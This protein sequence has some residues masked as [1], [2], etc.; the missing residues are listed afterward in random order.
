L[1]IDYLKP[2]WSYARRAVNGD[3]VVGKYI[4]L[5]C[6]RML[7]WANRTDIYFDE[8]DVDKKIRFVQK[9]KHS[10]GKHAG[11]YFTLLDYQQWIY[12]NIFGWKYKDTN[13][14][15]I[16]NVLLLMARKSGKTFLGASLALTVAVCDGQVSPEID[17]IANSSQQASIAFRHCSEQAKS[18][19]KNEK[20]FKRYRHNI[21]SP[22][23]GARI[24]VL[25]S[26]TSKLDGLGASMFLQDEGHEARS[27]E[28]WNILKT[29]QGA[30]E[31]PLAVGISTAGFHVGEAYPLYNQWAYGTRVLKGMIEDDTWFF[32]L[33]QI[34]E[35]DDWKDESVWI[36][37]NPSLGQTVGY[38][39][40]RDQIRSAINTPSNEVSIRTKNLNQFMQSSNI[41]ISHEYIQNVM[42]N[43]DLKD[44]LNEEAFGGCDLSVVCDLTAHSA[45]IPPNPDRKLNP[46]KFIFKSWLYIPEEALEMSSNREIYREWIRRGWAI[47]TA[48]N[49]VDYEHILKDQLEVAK[50]VYFIDYGY[51]AYNATSWAISAE[52][53]GLP[54]STFSQTLGNFNKPTKFFEMLVRSGKCIIDNN[55]AIDWCLS[56]VE[57]MWDHQ[58]NCKPTKANGDR[59]NKIDPVISMLE[60][61]GCYLASNRFQPESWVIK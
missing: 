22:V 57:L 25:S 5:A 1:Q 46:D 35:D 44:Y 38:D 55:P 4:K 10:E 31:N 9:M 26:D 3:I 41:W 40:M 27:F 34:D 2:Y 53:A 43:V 58:E 18:I 48:G 45:C 6:Q 49:V 28:V 14:R 23:T 24:N 54:L 20:I 12:A 21:Y 51:D 37:A 60:A 42:S 11:E 30:I 36:K 56:N 13:K 17:F 19:D 32:A 15:V 47:K 50:S 16:K 33:Y 61:L 29:S 8:S 39:Y 52:D 59:N 7:D